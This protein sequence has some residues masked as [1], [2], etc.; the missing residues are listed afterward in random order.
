MVNK[1]NSR[2]GTKYTISS[3]QRRILFCTMATVYVCLAFLVC[4]LSN[5]CVLW[6]NAITSIWTTKCPHKAVRCIYQSFVYY[7]KMR[8]IRQDALKILRNVCS[9]HN[10][11]K[12]L[13]HEQ[14]TKKPRRELLL[15][16]FRF[17]SR[18]QKR[19]R[20]KKKLNNLSECTWSLVHVYC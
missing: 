9:S 15:L 3:T 14:G 18:A 8:H 11:R 13:V 1:P 12:P 17:V 19:K 10:W 2:H 16:L 4:C 7:C 20:E 6:T 5:I